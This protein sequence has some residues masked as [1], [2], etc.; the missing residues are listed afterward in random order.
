MAELLPQ[1]I[2]HMKRYFNCEN[3]F[4]LWNR[5]S[6]EYGMIDRKGKKEY[7]FTANKY[8]KS[9]E[10]KEQKDINP[11]QL[12]V[13]KGIDFLDLAKEQEE[14][15][16]VMEKMKL[17]QVKSV[18]CKQ[19]WNMV[20]GIGGNTVA[21]VGMTL[22]FVNGVP[23]I[24]GQGIKGWM[25]HCV[26]QE[27]FNGDEKKAYKD[28]DFTAIFGSKQNEESNNEP[29]YAGNIIFYDAYPTNVPTLVKDIMTNHNSDYY[30][31]GKQV[32]LTDSEQPN[33]VTFLC[34]KDTEF[35]FN[36]GV[37]TNLYTPKLNLKT[38]TELLELV[39]KWFKKMIEW[40]GFG[41]KT[42]VGY[43]LFKYSEDE[44]AEENRNSEKSN[45][46][47]SEQ[48]SFELDLSGLKNSGMIRERK[49]KKRKI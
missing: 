16:K 17:I 47:E 2:Y 20:V 42:S 15:I 41:A 12:A 44:D 8:L 32:K 30:K 25:R 18:K 34:I 23:F 24:P 3:G 40:N 5:F 31:G 45:M 10:P 37:R 38:P 1:D 11:M 28:Y 4:L 35:L 22:H 26:V 39:E 48:E 36:F 19:E 46:L 21:E 9:L 27:V 43:G 13:S 14:A 33:P 49:K 29:M 6:A 7:K